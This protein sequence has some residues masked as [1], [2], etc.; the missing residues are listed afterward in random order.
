[1]VLNYCIPVEER[2]AHFF[3]Y[4]FAF[5]FVWLVIFWMLGVFKMDCFDA[6][7]WPYF[8]K[9]KVIICK[10]WVINSVNFTQSFSAFETIIT[11]GKVLHYIL[12]FGLT[13][14]SNFLFNKYSMDEEV[15]K[16]CHRNVKFIRQ[17][18]FNQRKSNVPIVSFAIWKYN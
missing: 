14:I 1:M 16:C 13:V 12:K 15:K 3:V 5:C 17:L 4:L 8:W 2:V 7:K 9:C 18:T 6:F 10:F 11:L